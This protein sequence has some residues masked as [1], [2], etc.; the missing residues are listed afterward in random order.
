MDHPNIIKLV[1]IVL[2]PKAMLLIEYAELGSLNAFSPY[3]S[4]SNHLKHRIAIQVQF[5]VMVIDIT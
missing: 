3:S 1:G 5:K 4:V 2:R